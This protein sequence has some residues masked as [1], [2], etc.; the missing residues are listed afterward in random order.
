MGALTSNR[1]RGDEFLNLNY[2][3]LYQNLQ[4]SKRPKLAFM[5]QSPNQNLVSSNSTVA[6]ISRYPERKPPLKRPV[7]GPCR[8]L[9]FGL[10]TADK[11]NK[12]SSSSGIDNGRSMG[13]ALTSRYEKAK[14]SAFGAFRFLTGYNDVT[15]VDDEQE[16]ET[17]SDDSSVEEVEEVVEDGRDGRSIVLDQRSRQSYKDEKHVVDVVEIYEKGEERRNYSHLQPSSSSAVTDVKNAEKMLDSLS[18][19][20]EVDVVYK[21][22]NQSAQKRNSKLKELEFAIDLNEKRRERI[23]LSYPV[24]QPEEEP[25]EEVPLEPFIELSEEEEYEVECAFATANRK[26]LVTHSGTAIDITGQILQCLRPGAWLNDE[27]INVYLGLLKEREK[28]EPQKF[29][30]CHFF[31]TFFYKKL[32]SGNRGYDFKAA[33]RWTTMKKLGYA[34]ID[35][36][37]VEILFTFFPLS[38]YVLLYYLHLSLNWFLFWDQ[39][40]VPIHQQIHWCL[41]VIN[42]RD[43]KFQYLDSLKGRD[44]KVLNNLAKYYVE[45][46]K[47]KSGKD[48]DLSDWELEFVEDLPE[49][50]N[51][52]D[53]GMFMLKYIDFYSRGLGLC[54]DQSCMPY[55]R[56][57]TAKEILRLRAD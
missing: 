11:F 14:R 24:K 22:L 27:V 15:E 42:K 7:H 30:K 46:V 44:G 5:Q 56:V 25:V 21:T 28:R 38:S 3:G 51:G 2:Q 33:K 54:F 4:V 57:R 12:D 45:E 47:D 29:L 8:P 55:F 10:G 17:V 36:D 35:C 50:E 13:N 1:K 20:R 49:Q 40:F 34:L 31:N 48:I 37:K 32:T 6:R 23:R 16:K 43:K 41:A 19:N 39:I 26:V 53:C 52:Y 9:K 18:L